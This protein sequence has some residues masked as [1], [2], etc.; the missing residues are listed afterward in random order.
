M[1]V[2]N[3]LTPLSQQEA[4][5][6]LGEAY[7]RVTGGPPTMRLLALLLAQTA[8]ETARWQKIHNFNFGNAKADASYP[9]V[10]QFRC[11]E[12]EQGVEYFFDPPD[13]HC[14]FRAYTNATDGA[15]DYVKVLRSRPHWWDG[16]QTEDP[17]AFVDAPGHRP[18][19]LH[20]QPRRL[21]AGCGVALR[22]IS[23]FS[24]RGGSGAAFG[25]LAVA[26]AIFVGTLRRPR[27]R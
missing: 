21:Q 15:V 27:R 10:T 17:N 6:A 20:R 3:R 4:S 9:L 24:A 1:I 23:P 2:A 13:P 8:F 19:V 7:A 26:A 5:S 12:V 14:N 16:L 11:S 22:R 18:E 25:V